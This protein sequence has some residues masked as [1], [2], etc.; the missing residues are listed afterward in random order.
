[1]LRIRKGPFREAIDPLVPLSKTWEKETKRLLTQLQQKDHKLYPR[2]QAWQTLF[3]E[4]PNYTFADPKI[5]EYIFKMMTLLNQLKGELIDQAILLTTT[6]L[7]EA[8]KIK[9]Y[10]PTE[11]SYQELL[12]KLQE[13]VSSYEEVV[14]RQK[15][16]SSVLHPSE[17]SPS[18]FLSDAIETKHASTQGR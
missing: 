3:D 8:D 12:R 7:A 17:T 6:F 15:T 16:F 11:I 9:E 14:K 13:Y 10:S 18:S 5:E 4:L 1:M 2:E